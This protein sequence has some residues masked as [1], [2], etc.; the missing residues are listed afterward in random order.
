MKSL[1]LADQDRSSLGLL[2]PQFR[3]TQGHDQGLLGSGPGLAPFGLRRRP[4]RPGD[5]DRR[6]TQP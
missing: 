5:S 3:L 1:G 4:L 2:S 6:L